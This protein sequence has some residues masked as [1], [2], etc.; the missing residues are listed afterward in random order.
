MEKQLTEL[1]RIGIIRPSSSEWGAPVLFAAKKDGTL[2]MCVDYRGINALTRKIRYPL[3]RIEELFDVLGRAKVFS[4]LDLK[5]GYHQLR[6]HPDAIHKTAFVTR[7]GQF[8]YVTAPFG[9]TNLPS[10]FQKLM[11]TTFRNEFFKFI[12][13]YLDD[14]VIFSNSVEEHAHHLEIVL[15]RLRNEK[16]YCHLAKSALFLST[17]TFLGFV[18]GNGQIQV[19]STKVDAIQRIQPPQNI[20]NLRMFLGMVT[21][22]RK[23]IPN[24]AQIAGPLFD[25]L[26][27]HKKGT[28]PHIRWGPDQQQ[29]FTL[30][31]QKI[32]TAP[33]LML[34]DLN[35]PQ[36]TLVTDCSDYA[37]GGVLL[38][39]HEEKNHPVA[40]ESRRLTEAETRYA[41][42]E[43]E[44]LAVVHCFKVWRHYLDGS[45]TTVFTDHQ[46]LQYF[47]S[48]FHLSKRLTKWMGYLAQYDYQIRYL[49]G[50]SNTLADGLSRLPMAEKTT[51][52]NYIQCTAQSPMDNYYEIENVFI[53]GK[54][55]DAPAHREDFKRQIKQFELDGEI[56]YRKFDG[57]TRLPYVPPTMRHDVIANLHSTL[58]HV[59]QKGLL[60]AVRQRG[61][62]PTLRKDVLAM[63]RSC[64][65]CQV[66]QSTGRSQR[67]AV[68]HPYPPMPLFSRWHLDFVGQLPTTTT[69][70]KWL[71]VA[72]DSLSRWVVARATPDA[73]AET[74]AKFIYEDIVASYG[75]PRELISDRGPAFTS[76][77]LSEFLSLLPLRQRFS[78]PYHPRTNGVVE[79]INGELVKILT[80][81]VQGAVRHWDK[82][83]SQAVFACRTRVNRSTGKSPF[84]LLYGIDP[85]LPGVDHP[86]FVFDYEE[87][88]ARTN[89]RADELQQLGRNR[90]AATL[91]LQGSQ[92]TSKFYYDKE[93]RRDPL[94]LRSWVLLRNERNVKIKGK[95]KPSWYGPYR[96]IGRSS[97][98]TYQLAEPNGDNL[99]VLIHR[100][101]LRT[102]DLGNHDPSE[103]FKRY[104]PT[105]RQRQVILGEASE[106]GDDS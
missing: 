33:V 75:C 83:V 49:K 84:Q 89:V 68:S 2:R 12:I 82:F 106:S 24:Y 52:I 32:S 43:K 39:Q 44:L 71:L 47:T 78:T 80:K 61:W 74:V 28:R 6:M 27:G 58:G 50:T 45:K 90:E 9:L 14:I 65:V 16:F 15:T 97:F 25:L 64:A 99:P 17:F 98:D 30:L 35:L 88:D 92:A 11:Q 19:D 59:G 70:N 62:W 72:I 22:L 41:T 55:P 100:D 73:T 102:A 4:R 48:T 3:P 40:Y 86:P 66:N 105:A 60:Q 26:K 36:Y 95:F 63:K 77:V 79:R 5:S 46:S 29:C 54:F 76:K 67:F 87:T 104:A 93:V 8:E 10:Y 53:K 57:G 42:H 51:E 37:L 13:I 69:G 56:L 91:R 7:F 20:T 18:I 101:R 85:I 38:Q 23:F 81:T 96:V 31:K 94:P 21:Y 1:L 103:L 34:P